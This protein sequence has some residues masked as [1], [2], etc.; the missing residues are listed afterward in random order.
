MATVAE[1]GEPISRTPPPPP[2]NSRWIA[3]RW[4]RCSARAAPSS[5]ACAR[6]RRGAS[7]TVRRRGGVRGEPQHQLHERVY[8]L[9]RVLRLQQRPSG[10]RT[11]TPRADV[12][13]GRRRGFPARRRGVGP[14]RDGGVHAGRDPP[15]FHGRELRPIVT[16]GAARRAEDHVHAFS[17]LEVTHGARTTG[18][19]VPAFIAGLRDEGLG[20]LP[21]TAAEVLGGAVRVEL[22]PDKISAK[23]GWTSSLR[24]TTRGCRPRRP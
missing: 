17:P 13:L 12:P 19:S 23:N 15:E 2:K 22:C 6:L 7:R 8:P 10:S 21:G 20:S 4:R 5:T 9:V 1:R 14:R 16:R 11:R 24:R 18:A 3:R